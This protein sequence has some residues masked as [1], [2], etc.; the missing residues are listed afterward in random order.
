MRYR[1]NLSFTLGPIG[2]LIIANLILFIA[3]SIN[4]D[5]IFLFGLQPAGFL[6]RPWTIVTN[7]FIHVG[8]GHI[9]T[10]MITLYFFGG[11]LI[12]LLGER[13]FFFIYFGGGLLG[14]IL[15]LLL[16]SPFSIAVGASG[17]VFALGGALALLR[18]RLTVFIFPI[19]I[20]IPLWV[21]VFGGFAIMS[22]LPFIAWQAHLG[23]LLFGL[24]TAYFLKRRRHFF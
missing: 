6:G 16:A 1:S 17:A 23:G 2:F 11:Y 7:L 14:S 20:P 24:G 9:L 18:P 8:F 3:T 5:I 19:P 21:A 15:Y 12:R 4:R 13:K 22:F 10:N